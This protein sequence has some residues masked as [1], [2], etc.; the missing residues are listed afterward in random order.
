M[1]ELTD[2]QWARIKPRLPKPKKRGRPRADDRKTINGILWVL[3]SGACWKNMPIQYGSP[4]T[5]WR[6]LIQWEEAGVWDQVWRGMLRN[7]DDDKRLEWARGFLDSS[8]ARAKK[9]A[10]KSV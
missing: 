1:D 2:A 6:R 3:R 8:F 5:C 10:P 4:V 9:G 7:L